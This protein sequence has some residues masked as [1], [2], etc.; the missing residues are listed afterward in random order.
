MARMRIGDSR[1]RLDVRRGEV[2]HGM[3]DVEQE[4]L[5]TL[6]AAES[7]AAPDVTSESGERTF[8]QIMADADAAFER[9]DRLIAELR[10]SEDGSARD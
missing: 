9:A 8:E 1:M 3:L 10:G 4:R 2:E 5:Q 6:Q 7:D